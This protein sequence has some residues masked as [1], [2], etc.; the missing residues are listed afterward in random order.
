MSIPVVTP[1]GLADLC[2]HAPIDLIDVRTPIEFRE[3]HIPQARNIPLD[4]LDS[5]ALVKE[6]NGRANEPFYVICRSGSRGRQAC[7]KLLAAGI[8]NAI[9]VEGG[10]LAWADCGLPL[11]RGKKMMSLERQSRIGAG[12][13]MWLGLLLS[14]FVHPAFIG[15]SAFVGCGLIFAGITDICGM[16]LLLARMPWNQIKPNQCCGATELCP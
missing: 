4:R 12:T 8:T 9:N 10:T 3:M 7:E 14:W 16:G 5:M 11:V 13:V 6:R 2:N 15:L 1:R